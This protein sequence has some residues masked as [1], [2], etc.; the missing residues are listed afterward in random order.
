MGKSPLLNLLPK[1]ACGFFFALIDGL[2]LVWG[3]VIKCAVWP[4]SVIKF[5]IGIN[6]FRKSPLGCVMYTIDFFPFHGCGYLKLPLE[7]ILL[8][9]Q[10]FLLLIVSFRMVDHWIGPRNAGTERPPQ[11]GRRSRERGL[12]PGSRWAFPCCHGPG[13]VYRPKIPPFFRAP[14]RSEEWNKSVRWPASMSCGNRPF[15]Q[16]HAA[17][18]CPASL[19]TSS[20]RRKTFG[21]MPVDS[22]NA[23]LK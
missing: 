3:F 10:A 13:G 9:G 12:Q 22:L 4:S 21:D 11:P 17:R 2:K 18:Q 20:W 15:P 7:E 23:W 14:L 1:S 19:D 16:P 6:A 8:F 5:D